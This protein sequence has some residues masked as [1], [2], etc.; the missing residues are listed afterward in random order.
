MVKPNTNFCYQKPYYEKSDKADRIAA[1]LNECADALSEASQICEGK[2][3]VQATKGGEHDFIAMAQR[4]DDAAFKLRIWAFE[5]NIEDLDE[6]DAEKNE[7]IHL[8]SVILKRLRD[9]IV[10]LKKLCQLAG[11][12]D[13]VVPEPVEYDSD[14]D[15]SEDSGLAFK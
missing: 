14:D 5:S 1:R 12:N 3:R 15:L 8:A 2:S 11:A 13:L 9:R 6:S 10:D 7:A 4:L